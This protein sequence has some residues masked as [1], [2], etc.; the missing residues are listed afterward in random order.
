MNDIRRLDIKIAQMR[1]QKRERKT[2]LLLI[3][4]LALTVIIVAVT[5]SNLKEQIEG[6]QV[7]TY[8][9]TTE[10][11]GHILELTAE[12]RVLVERVVAAE[13]RGESLMGQMAVAQVI[14]DRCLLGDL[15]VTE[16]VY[17]KDQF[18]QPYDGEISSTTEAAVGFVFEGGHNVFEG[19]V[20]HFY[21]HD[22]IDAPDWTNE[23]TFVGEIGG[24]SFYTE[25]EYATS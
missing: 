20:T 10:E 3:G 19:P 6:L 17:A 15:Q 21:A 18:A 11:T 7:A 13:A 12:E 16:V 2:L 22:L 1:K 24:H 8:A 14:R 4:V 25:A 23:I 5:N 9:Q